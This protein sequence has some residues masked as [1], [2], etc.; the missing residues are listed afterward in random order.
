MIYKTP[1][2]QKESGRIELCNNL[3]KIKTYSKSTAFWQMTTPCY[4]IVQLVVRHVFNNKLKVVK[5]GLERAPKRR[6]ASKDVHNKRKYIVSLRRQKL[7]GTVFKLSLVELNPIPAPTVFSYDSHQNF[8]RTPK[9]DKFNP[10][11]NFSQ[12]KHD[13]G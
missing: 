10:L 1:K 9:I 4:D 3:K 11:A 12:F 6:I 7:L 2:S 8:D 13:S 5:S